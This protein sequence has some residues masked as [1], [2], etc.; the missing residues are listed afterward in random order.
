MA[1]FLISL[2]S[3]GENNETTPDNEITP[4]SC[5][6]GKCTF[7]FKKNSQISLP[8]QSAFGAITDGNNLVF[9]RRFTKDDKAYIAD[10]ELTTELIFEVPS[11]VDQFEIAT[12]DL[13][14]SKVL[15]H[16]ICFCVKNN[17]EFIDSG[18][19]TGTKLS[20][21]NWSVNAD[22]ITD[23]FKEFENLEPIR[24]HFDETFV[25]D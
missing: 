6:S 14:G 16:Q 1:L 9:I 21:G 24:I 7:T 3:C 19:I 4:E 5:L 8:E 12:T 22:L 2:G 10:D 23:Y 17:F 18:K 15:Y 25:I 13:I 20:D 11:D